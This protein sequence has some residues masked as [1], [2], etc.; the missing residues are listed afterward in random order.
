MSASAEST[1]VET[2]LNIGEHLSAIG[3]HEDAIELFEKA[4]ATCRKHSGDDYK[5]L[6]QILA[7]IGDAYFYISRFDSSI[8]SCLDALTISEKQTPMFVHVLETLA[9]SYTG[10]GI[11]KQALT[12]YEQVLDIKR[13]VLPPDHL[14]IADTIH[15][16]GMTLQAMGDLAQAMD[17]F[18][19]ALNIYEKQT[20]SRDMAI[21]IAN[22]TKNLGCVYSQQGKHTKTIKLLESVLQMEKEIGR[23][24][25][26]MV[27][28]LTNLG[29]AYAQLGADSRAMSNYNRALRLVNKQYR[30]DIRME[31]G[32]LLY[33]VAI[34]KAL[35]CT[36][37]AREHLRR[38]TTIF[39]TCLGD[40]HP[41]TLQAK[42]FMKALI[43][44]KKQITR[45]KQ[46]CSRTREKGLK[47]R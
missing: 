10:K 34:A 22:V 31:I 9:R 17:A 4:A 32:D 29:V 24:D 39:A 36:Q 5:R 28:T 27:N 13:K 19:N 40:S 44:K 14:E 41:K 23:D 37:S 15:N 6:I 47:K 1:R 25:I 26:S 33:N 21:R 8:R 45:R 7:R 20:P 11:Y 2:L 38:C 43:H 16:R 18:Q 42:A 3:K 12:I 46:Y 30:S 35:I